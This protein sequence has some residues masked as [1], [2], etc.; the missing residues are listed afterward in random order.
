MD[1]P[2]HDRPFYDQYYFHPSYGQA[3]YW[4]TQT[5]NQRIFG[6]QVFDWLSSGGSLPDFS[7]RRTI[8]EWVIRAFEEN[9]GVNFDGFDVV[10][11]VVALAKT[12]K[13]DGGSS[14]ANSKHRSHN[15]VVTRVGDS[16]DFVAHELGHGMGLTHSFGTNPIAVEGEKPGGYGHPFCIMSA[17]YYGNTAAPYAPPKPRED[18][19]E[20]SGLGPSL[21]GLTAHANGWIDAYF[22]DLGK[23][24]EADFTIRARQWLGRTQSATAQGLELLTPDGSN[25]VVDFYVPEGWDQGQSGPAV[26]LTQGRG[27]RAQ[28]ADP[29]YA[30]ANAGTYVTH[31]RLPV[32]YGAPG[33]TL[34]G[35]GFR[36]HVL[37]YNATTREV[38]IRVRRGL[39]AAPDVIM[40][41]RVDTLRSPTVETGR[42]TWAP[43]EALCLTGTWPYE[44][45]ARS[46]QAVIE[47]TYELNV[48][49]MQAQ[50]TIEGVALPETA[51]ALS[52]TQT[53]TVNV[54]V[55][56]PKFQAVHQ[57][58]VISL[59]FDIEPLPNG[60]RLKLRN[61]PQ[62]ETFKL[63]IEV[64]LSNPAGSG[65]AIS[66]LD[67]KGLEYV[68]PPEFYRQRDACYQ[69]FIDVGRRY[70]RYKVVPF[71]QLWDQVDPLRQNEVASWL[72]ALAD[73]Q[74]RGEAQLYQQGA[75]ALARELGVADLGLQVL[76]VEEAYSPP[77]ILHEI[78]PPARR[79]LAVTMT[80]AR[81][82]GAAS[83][84]RLAGYLLAGAIGAA[85]ATLWTRPRS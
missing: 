31:A 55:A 2:K 79:D 14:G 81:D 77:Q 57:S 10:V 51:T 72:D 47:A 52:G 78:A 20:Y 19:V 58:K 54:T 38:R 82:G 85:L 46:Q 5:D 80:A 32:I 65:S 83:G 45:I 73:R 18:A 15:A 16:F 1:P 3:G 75:E 13:S 23:T 62:D 66:W 22:M 44:K 49:G 9:R 41:W 6:G 48:P 63:R 25:Y 26:V 17:Q 37:D 33:S 12:I 69:H 28:L 4:G 64:T 84:R 34:P 27:G 43:G 67:F 60:S 70:L 61:R 29:R 59:D 50:W 39:G 68:Y 21:N 36:I 53:L 35:P 7:K 24:A 56:D 11:V 42:T 76:S 40:D 30:A 8:A 71:P 74:D